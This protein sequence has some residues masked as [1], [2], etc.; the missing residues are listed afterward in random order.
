MAVAVKGAFPNEMA[1]D[2]D[3]IFFDQYT[4]GKPEMPMIAKMGSFPAGDTYTESEMTGLG[5]WEQIYDAQPVSYDIP[6]E[7]HKKSVKPYDFGK[8]FQITRNTLT[9]DLH[10]NWKK[11]PATL[12]KG[13][14]E[15]KEIQFWNLFNNGFAGGGETCWDL[16]AIFAS[17]T[18]LKPKG[19]VTTCS[20]LGSA[21]L[22]DVSLKAAF[23]HYDD[24]VDESGFRMRMSPSI[25]LIPPELKWEAN[26]LQKATGK[27]WDYTDASKGEIRA[28]TAATPSVSGGPLTLPNLIQPSYGIVDEWSIMV[29]HYL[30]DSDAWFLLSREHDFRF[31]WKQQMSL[32][33]KDDFNTRSR[34]YQATMRFRAFVMAWRGSYGSPG[35]G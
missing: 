1:K 35:A 22:A 3:K 8:G 13:A 19:A 2:I 27:V 23:E 17:H 29:S 18:L 16:G 33:S 15:I 7:G 20:N 4:G 28:A 11:M 5:E 30:T 25:L 10:G 32:E 6:A 9:D 21:D 31:W 12:G 26:T 14:A 34:L 24:L